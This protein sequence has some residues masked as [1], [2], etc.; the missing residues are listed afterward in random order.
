MNIVIF[1]TFCF[2]KLKRFIPSL[3][4]N[5]SVNFDKGDEGT[6]MFTK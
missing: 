2:N 1:L 4:F 6:H 5:I 3:I